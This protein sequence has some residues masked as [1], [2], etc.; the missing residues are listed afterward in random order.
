VA[1]ALSCAF[2][3]APGPVVGPARDHSRRCGRASA[4]RKPLQLEPVVG[5]WGYRPRVVLPSSA[6]LVGRDAE[7]AAIAGWVDLLTVGPAGLVIEGEAGIGK[8]SLLRIAADLAAERDAHLL[9]ARPVEAELALGYS[10]LGDLLQGAAEQRIRD[11]PAPQA[12]ALLA[13]L[14]LTAPPRSG[15]PLLV[16]R[17]TLSLLRLLAAEADVVLVID[18]VQWLDAPSRRA[19]GFV[20]RRLGTARV[21]IAVTAR[22]PARDPLDLASAMGE[23]CVRVRLDGLSFGAI[24]HLVRDRIAHDIPRRRLLGIHQRSG[25]N[26]FYALELARADSEAVGL[27]PTL[28]QLIMRRLDEAAGASAAVELLAVLGPSPVS[29]LGPP[30]GVDA[31]V[32]Q[33]VL[34]EH[35]GEIRFSHPLLAA[36]AYARIPPARRRQLHRQSAAGVSSIEERARHL[37]LAASGPD[38]G[39][40]ALLDEAAHH[41]RAR[42]ASETAAALSAQARRLTPEDDD[43]ARDRRAIDEAESLLLAADET[44]ARSLAQTV[45]DGP[46]RGEVR[47]RAL[48]VRATTADNPVSAVR[49]LE[50]AV[51]EP[52]QDRPLA[53][54]ALAQLAWQ[55]GAWLGD[56]PAALA[57]AES[58][59]SEASRLDDPETLVVALTA[60]GLLR[61]TAGEPGA[62]ELFRRAIEIVERTGASAGDHPPRIA[63]AHERWWRGDFT[64]AQALLGEERRVAES[65]GDDGLLM[66]LNVF[67]GELNLRWGRWDDAARWI[68]EAL[69]DARGYWRAV[70][71]VRRAML[72]ARRGDERARE[73]ADEVRR[74]SAD[75]DP[76]QEAA[77]NF[78][79]ALLEQADG[80]AG[81]A[82][83]LLAPSAA[84]SG[85]SPAV[86]AADLAMTVPEMVS[87]LVEAG[88]LGQ[89]TTLA[90]DLARRSVQLA[91]W[92]DAAA[93]MCRGMIANG[94]G[95][96]DEALNELSV[97]HEGFARL[98]APWELAQALLA[99]GSVLRRLGQR[100]AAGEVL[101]QALAIDVSLGAAPAARRVRDEL[102]RARPRPRHDDS[103]TVTESRV[104]ALAARGMTNRE[105]AAQQFVTVA[106][107]EAHLT[108]I[109]AKLGV[110]SRT[111]LV[112]RVSEGSLNLEA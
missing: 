85:R 66:R 102:H 79:L 65:R 88:D 87:I 77:A 86:L 93:A 8:T 23:R 101:E 52:L 28:E 51:V 21:G 20:A 25:G 98:G 82:A 55:R 57:E 109:Y 80:R 111:E 40:A 36:G 67:D 95:R 112:R 32:A 47:V 110:R 15:D 9:L 72:R 84:G 97:A 89:A 107:V 44:D 92:G 49:D 31:G 26:P 71:L 69:I 94:S 74:L 75:H 83:S 105:I 34:I 43:A 45:L 54:R 63:F 58:A 37:A 73:D 64:T 81:E 30:E 50:A 70:A 90:D 103:L 91:P 4:S 108:R 16:A 29:A 99:E 13:A 3:P 22:D 6:E 33:G 59:L 42:G 46:T 24:G 2:V 10:G 61:S 41:A 56:M 53:A 17:A 18:D 78:A 11:L 27:P 62:A 96:S 38:A 76:G 5:L 12:E 104:A 19:I 106:T 39:V 100:R 7:I 60:A 68:E 14:S 48:L 1:K 35:E